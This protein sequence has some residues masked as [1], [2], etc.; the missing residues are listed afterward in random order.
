VPFTSTAVAEIAD[1]FAPSPRTGVA[2]VAVIVLAAFE[3]N[4]IDF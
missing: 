4:V 3:K 1:A 2:T